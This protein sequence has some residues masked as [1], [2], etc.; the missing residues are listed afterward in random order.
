MVTP[1]LAP[2]LLRVGEGGSGSQW[3]AP[4]NASFA[5]PVQS[6]FKRNVEVHESMILDGRTVSE[7]CLFGVDSFDLL[8]VVNRICFFICLLVDICFHTYIKT[9]F[10]SWVGVCSEGSL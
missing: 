10:V 7:W 5:A 1:P 9:F 8:T 2:T 3:S 4:Q 6:Q